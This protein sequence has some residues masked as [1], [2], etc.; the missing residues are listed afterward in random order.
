MR[1]INSSPQAAT[2]KMHN[3]QAITVGQL[4]SQPVFAGNDFEIQF[5]RHPVRLHAQLLDQL[6]ERKRTFQC[7]VFSVDDYFHLC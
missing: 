2:H 7:A 1:F 6:T 5:D 4:S 3:L